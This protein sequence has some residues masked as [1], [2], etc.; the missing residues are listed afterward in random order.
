M[1]VLDRNARFE[2]PQIN[3]LLERKVL[4][5]VSVLILGVR[6]TIPIT[7]KME[8]AEV[9]CKESVA[10]AERLK[11]KIEAL[12]LKF[13]P[14]NSQ[15]LHISSQDNDEISLESSVKSL[16]L[17]S[18][19]TSAIESDKKDSDDQDK[20]HVLLVPQLRNE[21]ERL[22]KA[23]DDLKD[24]ECQLRHQVA[25]TTDLSIHDDDDDAT[26]RNRDDALLSQVSPIRSIRS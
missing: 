22:R 7:E 13:N 15:K 3:K 21:I 24:K 16:T 19:S 5:N 4:F 17:S 6:I 12:E 8:E 10:E 14:S 25:S 23:Y 20:D 11:T 1:P 18:D 26:P 9:L 2:F